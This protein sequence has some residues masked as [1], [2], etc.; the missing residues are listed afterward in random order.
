MTQPFDPTR[1]DLLWQTRDLQP[2]FATLVKVCDLLSESCGG[3]PG[4]TVDE[5][6]RNASI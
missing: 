5:S 3:A 2:L 1:T 4:Y 6:I